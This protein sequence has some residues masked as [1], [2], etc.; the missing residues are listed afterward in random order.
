[1]KQIKNIMVCLDLTE[2]DEILIRYVQYIFQAFEDVQKIYFVHNVKFDF[3]LTA[4]EII[5]N[6][7]QP[8]RTIIT[9]DIIEKIEQIFLENAKKINYEVI[10][11]ENNSTPLVL[12][13]IANLNN[14]DL[15]ITGK[16]ISFKGTGQLNEKLLR[17]IDFKAL[18]LM[19]PE[20]SY[21]QIK[22]ILVPTDFSKGSK[23]AIELALEINHQTNARIQCQHVFNIPSLYFP[24]IP[25]NN[26]EEKLKNNALKQW[27]IFAKSLHQLGANHLECELTFSEGKNT[28]Q[29][30]YDFAVYQQKDLI[31]I[32]T[33]GRGAITPFPIGSVAIRLIQMDLHIPLLITK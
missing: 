17:T 27:S 23:K 31:V 6:L 28:A 16:K 29:T 12:A 7:D 1:M 20:T 18:L 21:H 2:M 3:P 19:V 15:V 30:I 13:R 24:Y 33:K 5:N 8:L 14:I 22:N 11:E 9:E 32:N 25:V 10:I 26:M 4:Q